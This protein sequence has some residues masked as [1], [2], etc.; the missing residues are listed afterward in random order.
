M[1]KA[2]VSS[3]LTTLKTILEGYKTFVDEKATKKKE[4]AQMGNIYAQSFLDQKIKEETTDEIIRRRK[5]VKEEVSRTIGAIK[6]DITSWIRGEDEDTAI[7]NRLNTIQNANVPM[8]AEEIKL[9]FAD[10]QGRYLPMKILSKIAKQNGLQINTPDAGTML[11]QLESLESSAVSMVNLYAGPDMEFKD[12]VP[13]ISLN[14]VNYGRPKLFQLSTSDL[15]LRNDKIGELATSWGNSMENVEITR[16]KLTDQ[17][18]AKIDSLYAGCT[19][20]EEKLSRTDALLSASPEM[21]STLSLSKYAQYLPREAQK[22]ISIDHSEKI[23]KDTQIDFEES[24][25]ILDMYS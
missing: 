11:K 3:H 16:R 25:R 20:R 6:N 13:D 1:F 5:S 12:T 14:G 18:V 23:A 7:I 4:L 21:R 19:T 9:I 15:V 8:D 2:K 24:K 22:E 17:E 10:C